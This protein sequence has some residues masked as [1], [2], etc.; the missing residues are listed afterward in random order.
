MGKRSTQTCPKKLGSIIVRVRQEVSRAGLGGCPVSISG[1]TPGAKTT[2]PAGVAEFAGLSHGSYE[3]K[4]TLSRDAVQKHYKLASYTTTV[5]VSQ[6]KPPVWVE[7]FA[8]PP[9][10]LR[11]KVIWKKPL[12]DGRLLDQLLD[13]MKVKIAG[14]AATDKATGKDGNAVFA[15]IESGNYTVSAEL[16]GVQLDRFLAPASVTVTLPPGETR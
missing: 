3:I 8:R 13:N 16:L 6:P 4:I 11:T 2:N 1:P 14:P 10:T 12:R 5:S 15:D 9:S 7:A